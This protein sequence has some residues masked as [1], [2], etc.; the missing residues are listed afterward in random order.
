V[1]RAPAEIVLDGILRIAFPLLAPSAATPAGYVTE[2]VTGGLEVTAPDGGRLLCAAGP[3]TVP[4]P[5]P[6]AAPYDAALLDLLGDPAQLGGLRRRGLVTDATTVAV[7]HVDHRLPAERELA[8]RCGLWRAI[9]ATDGDHLS[10]PAAE[11]RCGQNV[12]DA[13]GTPHP[14][15]RGTARWVRAP[16]PTLPR[17][18]RTL[19][20]GGARSGKSAEAERRLA[21]EPEVTYVAAAGPAGDDD[22]DW[23]ARLAAHQARRPRWW[24]TVETTDIAGV[25]RAD[26]GAVL[27]DSIGSW[28]AA[29]LDE[30]G[31]WRQPSGDPQVASHLAERISQLVCAWRAARGYIVAVSEEAGSGVVPGTRSGRLFRDQL[32]GLNQ[33]LAAESEEA[34][35]V[36]AGRVLPL[37]G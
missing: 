17:P 15:G 35:L 33:L 29:V 32:G 28:L 7:I 12:Q 20:L 18:W 2:L 5:P 36:V 30:T 31:A 25:L 13:R 6:G 16:A 11:T 10:V 8:R 34:V 27:I 21:A 24:R 14:A 1:A 22:P 9:A 4:L 3:G 37:P 26:T 23:L 19:V